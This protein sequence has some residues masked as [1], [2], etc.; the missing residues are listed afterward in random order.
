MLTSLPAS[1]QQASSPL[2]LSPVVNGVVKDG[3]VSVL[4]RNN[5]LL[6]DAAGLSSIGI[7]PDT[8]RPAGHGAMF[9]PARGPVSASIDAA[10]QIVRFSVPNADLLTNVTDLSNPAAAVQATPGTGAYL[11]YALS[12][13]PATGAGAN[14]IP[15]MAT[16]DMTGDAFS[17]FGALSSSILV[18]LPQDKASN[19]GIVTRLNTSYQYD[20]PQIPRSWTAGDLITQTPG[21]GRGEF[22]GGIQLATDYGLQPS[23]ITFPTPVIGQTLAQ[24][25]ALSLLVN[26]VQAYNANAA[27]GPFSLVGIPVLNGLNQITVQTRTGSGDVISQTVPF[28]ASSSMLRQGLTEY[29]LSAGLLR[30]HYAQTDD[31][32]STLVFNGT[33][34]RGLADDLTATLHSELAPNLV[35]FGLG[36]EIAGF[37]GDLATALAVAEHSAYHDFPHQNGVLYSAQYQRSSPGF[38]ISA[39]VIKAT[40]GYDDLGLETNQIYPVLSWHVSGSVT[41]PDNFGSLA[42]AFTEE[43]AERHNR[44][45]FI[46]ASYSSQITRGLT[47]SL[48]CFH[49]DVRGFGITTPNEGCDAELSLALGRFGTVGASGAYGSDQRP[50]LGE[51]YQNFPS[52]IQGVGAAA[53]N[54]SG[55]YLSRNLRLQDINHDAELAANVAQNGNAK[56]AEFD[57]NGSLIA[58]DGLYLSRPTNDSFAVVD[59]GYP[60]VPVFLS[61]QP[62]GKTNPSGRMLIP[63]L[64]PYYANKISI[65]PAALPMSVNISDEEISV[66]PPRNGGVL[67]RFP[68]KQ[69]DAELLHISLSG[70]GAPPA[71]SLLYLAQSPTPIVVGYDGYAYLED[72]PRHLQ[73]TIIMTQGECHID[74]VL[75]AS[76]HDALVGRKVTCKG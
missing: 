4:P 49:G 39:G 23:A 30:H 57:V 11:D 1:A 52:G 66:T 75:H 50:E 62:V 26:N 31:F 12:L 19:Q 41:L 15:G 33:V 35:L 24:P 70:G 25:S 56:S 47:F 54:L 36:G 37:W 69:L 60:K 13:R 73:A 10:N 32:Y 53:S 44:D 16:A 38:G 67:A 45:D 20:Q 72:P 7:Q 59:F 64:V 5:G 63:N 6:I 21:W 17:R 65:D 3:V 61:N 55:D 68:V 9:I 48:S 18:Q 40:S 51:S 74:L 46:L 2:Y 76:V 71:G 27:A 43:S 8:G 29:S 22:I 28:Y 58:M 34:S 42:L 14:R